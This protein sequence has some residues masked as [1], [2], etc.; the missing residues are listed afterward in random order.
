MPAKAGIQSL[1]KSLKFLDSLLRGNDKK[2]ASPAFYGFII[3]KVRQFLAK[4][5]GSFSH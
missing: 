4:H 3:L 2:R 5:N 1:V